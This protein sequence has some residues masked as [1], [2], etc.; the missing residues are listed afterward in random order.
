[1]AAALAEAIQQI[2]P[3]AQAPVVFCLAAIAVLV[4]VPADPAVAV[5]PVERVDPHWVQLVRVALELLLRGRAAVGLREL[6]KAPYQIL[7]EVAV[8][9]VDIHT[10]YLLLP[11][12]VPPL[13]DPQ[14]HGR[15]E[16][17]ESA[18]LVVL[19]LQGM[20]EQMLMVLLAVLA[21]VAKSHLM[22]NDLWPLSKLTAHFRS[23]YPT[24]NRS[25][26]TPLPC[27]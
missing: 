25:T 17:V 16:R 10:V 23:T 8:A 13:Q 12:L 4:A 5:K 21:L 9:A 6:T 26:R 2:R 20:Y 14:F 18:G 11:L 15:W 27:S 1:M 22:W 3:A 19:R 24:A 7:P